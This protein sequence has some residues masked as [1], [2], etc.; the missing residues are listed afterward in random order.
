MGDSGGIIKTVN[1]FIG[2]FFP[3]L[4]ANEALPVWE[5]EI[6]FL[7]VLIFLITNVNSI[8]TNLQAIYKRLMKNYAYTF[9]A[10]SLIIVSS[11]ASLTSSQVR[12]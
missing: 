1:D 9:A 2:R 12:S 8:L 7:L 6:C 3:S 5:Q 10:G 11:Y 4:L